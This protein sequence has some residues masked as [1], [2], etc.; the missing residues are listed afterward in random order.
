MTNSLNTVRVAS[1]KDLKD[2]ITLCVNAGGKPLALFQVNGT[3]YATDNACPHAGGPL[4]DGAV[5]DGVVTCPWHGSQFKIET[6]EVVHGPA[7]VN[8]QTY[9]VEIHGEDV[10]IVLDQPAGGDIPKQVAYAFAPELDTE[11]PFSNEGFLND[12]LQELKF[13]FKLYGTLPFIVISQSPDEIDAHLGELHVTEVDLQALSGIMKKLN[14]KWG[15]AIT[16][17]IFQSSQFPGAM[18]LNIRG[19]HAP[20]NVEK[21]IRF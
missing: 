10:V 8:V 7:T 5:K 15:T 18:L 13:P 6:G 21:S 2:G 9:P 11:R 4:C 14:E 17:C 12:L 19:P 16:Y 3:Y 1:V 20:M